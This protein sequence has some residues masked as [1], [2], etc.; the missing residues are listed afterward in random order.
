M[1]KAIFV[2]LFLIGSVAFAGT[3]TTCPDLSTANHPAITQPWIVRGETA[4]SHIYNHALISQSILAGVNTL[5][6]VYNQD[7]SLSLQK[8]GQF[9]RGGHDVWVSTEVGGI[10]FWQCLAGRDDCFFYSA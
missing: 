9:Q 2:F 6:C 1:R 4:G 10:D 3:K 5:T 8:I 7:H